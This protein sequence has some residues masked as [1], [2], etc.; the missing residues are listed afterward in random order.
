M[1]TQP[2]QYMKIKCIEWFRLQRQLLVAQGL[3]A[4]L[5]ALIA[6]VLRP[7]LQPLVRWLERHPRARQRVRHLLDQLGLTHWLRRMQATSRPQK[8]IVLGQR[9]MAIRNDLQRAL[10]ALREP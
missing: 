7:L 6:K 8:K 9:G 1:P 3:P 2:P 10:A 5:N 4:R